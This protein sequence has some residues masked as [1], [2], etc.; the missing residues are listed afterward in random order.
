[1]SDELNNPLSISFS[2]YMGNEEFTDSDDILRLIV[3]A[4]REGTVIGIKS[5]YLG[6]LMVLTGVKDFVL[7]EPPTVTLQPYDL[8][9][10]ILPTTHVPLDSII[11]VQP[12]KSKFE[13][14]IVSRF[15][16]KADSI[17]DMI[18]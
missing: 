9:G 15:D 12:F 10:Y 2:R 14:P 7:D 8:T 1:M 11:A 16:Q 5:S 6:R 13:N 3:N 18:A 4:Q 17:N